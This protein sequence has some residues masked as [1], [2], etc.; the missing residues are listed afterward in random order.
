MPT[1]M[2]DLITRMEKARDRLNTAMDKVNT[3]EEIYPSWKLKQVLDHITGWDELANTT[4][5]AY[6][7]GENPARSVKSINQYNDASVSARQAYTLE[8]SR[9]AYAAARQKML[10]TLRKLPSELFT[11]E[12]NAPW[13][14]KCTIPGVMKIFISH[15][16]EHA[17]QIEGFK[18]AK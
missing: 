9:Q 17:R 3:Q 16:L 5:Q 2:D 12:F 15:E 18:L 4:L 1:N 14:G 6:Q 7:R 11:L 10:G 8:Q 13:G